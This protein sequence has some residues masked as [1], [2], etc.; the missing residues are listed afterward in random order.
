M[1][2]NHFSGG[3][4][5]NMVNHFISPRKQRFG[6]FLFSSPRFLLFCLY[7]NRKSAV[8]VHLLFLFFFSNYWQCFKI[9]N[10]VSS[11]K[12]YTYHV[13]SVQEKIINVSDCLGVCGW[14]R[15]KIK[16]IENFVCRG[17][18]SLSWFPT[19]LSLPMSGLSLRR[20]KKNT[21]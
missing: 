4:G 18:E 6:Y 12:C 20:F 14:W 7:W 3:G 8:L 13:N 5:S 19:P 11:V 21:S 10:T 2:G 16:K 17:V 15:N 1:W 9:L